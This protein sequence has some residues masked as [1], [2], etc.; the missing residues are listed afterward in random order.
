MVWDVREESFSR[1]QNQ[2]NGFDSLLVNQF[3]QTDLCEDLA[4]KI[5]IDNCCKRNGYFH[6]SVQWKSMM[7]GSVIGWNMSAEEFH[8]N[9]FSSSSIRW[10]EL[11]DVIGHSMIIKH[12]DPS[13]K[14]NFCCRS[15][16]YGRSRVTEYFR[17]W[18][19]CCGHYWVSMFHQR[20]SPRN[21]NLLSHEAIGGVML[22][23]KKLFRINICASLEIKNVY[24][25]DGVCM[26]QITVHCSHCSVVSHH[27]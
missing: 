1:P 12:S 4:Y 24:K 3:C 7:D 2:P 6:L 9:H 13:S 16:R 17:W 14:S 15:Q 10:I 5:I 27:S 11:S 19:D 21:K 26:E 20:H 25:C 18:F 8:R 22:E 23:N